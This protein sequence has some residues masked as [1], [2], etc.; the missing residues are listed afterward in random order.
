MSASDRSV[1]VC[2]GEV[3][4]AT[5]TTTAAT[6]SQP[7]LRLLDSLQGGLPGLVLRLVARSEG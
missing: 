3:V 7:G 2:P 4:T 6:P 1:T 5:N